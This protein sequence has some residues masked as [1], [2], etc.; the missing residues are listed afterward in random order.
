MSRAYKGVSA[1][2]ASGNFGLVGVDKDPGVASRA[3]A[4]VAR[5]NLVVSPFDRHLVHQF[6]RSVRL[7]LGDALIL[8]PRISC[9]IPIEAFYLEAEVGLF[10]SG[11]GH[12]QCSRLLASGPDGGS[13]GSLGDG[14]GIG[15]EDNVR[16]ARA[17]NGRR[18]LRFQSAG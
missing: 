5:H 10:E 3:A 16:L 15:L 13:V 1:V 6:D 4:A 11:A 17:G 7:G 2:V 9:R 14:I 12:G 8:H 18:S